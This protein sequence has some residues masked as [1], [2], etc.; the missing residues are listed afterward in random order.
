M[1]HKVKIKV[2]LGHRVNKVLYLVELL[3]CKEMGVK[4]FF[5]VEDKGILTLHKVYKIQG[6]NQ[7]QVLWI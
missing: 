7:L 1:I 6:Y 5:Q 3:L 2:F 4:D